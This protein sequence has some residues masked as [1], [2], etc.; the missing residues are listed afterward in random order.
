MDAG[1]VPQDLLCRRVRVAEYHHIPWTKK[2]AE[3]EYEFYD[4]SR[5]TMF[6]LW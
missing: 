2:A 4:Q 6:S 1:S 3:R 5:D